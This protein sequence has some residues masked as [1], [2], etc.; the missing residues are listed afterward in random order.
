MATPS[1]ATESVERPV[2]LL[3]D[4][5]RR[6]AARAPDDLA[7]AFRPD[8]GADIRLTVGELHAQA[9]AIAAELSRLASPGE[10]AILLFPPGLEFVGAFFGCLYAG[11]IAV[12]LAPPRRAAE[13]DH[14][15]AIIADCGARIVLTLE[16]FFAGVRPEIAEKYRRDGLQM[17]HVDRLAPGVEPPSPPS[18]DV[19]FIQYTSGSTGSPKGVA[20]SHANLL[21]NLETIRLAMGNDAASTYAGWGPLYHDLGLIMNV[22]QPLYLGAAC[23]LMAPASFVRRPLSWLRLI[24]DYR[25]EVAGG[26]NFAFD[27]CVDRLRPEAMEGVDLSCWKVAFNGS[28]P[29]RAATLVRF[30][31]AFAPYGFDRAALYPCYGLAE[32]TLLVAAGRRGQGFSVDD[33]LVSNG[34]AAPGVETA[35]VDPQTCARVPSGAVGEI[36]VAG[37]AVARGYWRRPDETML[38]FGAQIAD[39]PGRTWLRTGDLGRFDAQGGLYVTGRIKDLILV[40]GV[41]H[42]PQDIE[43]TVQALGVRYRRARGAA[44][45]APDAHGVERLVIVQEVESGLRSPGEREVM[46]GDVR[47]AVSREHELSV[48]AAAFIA[49]GALPVTTSGKVRRRETRR[50]WLE[51]AFEVEK[52]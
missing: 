32:A 24:H 17:V 22:L 16:S 11:V 23:V 46:L 51:G 8:A 38:T 35:V 34:P 27:L 30:A 25:A 45:T 47:E 28:E 13:R 10:R 48:Y 21:A 18:A 37:P 5:L 14:N 12:P 1:P 40:R 26:P 41:N 15:A 19:A 29:V 31:E 9:C 39:E 49:R 2:G 52:P 3:G 50:L 33:G 4:I 20:V 44:F 36:W 42:Y 43:A 6:R 7:L